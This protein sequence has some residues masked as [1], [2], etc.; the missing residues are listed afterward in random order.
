MSEEESSPEWLDMSEEE[1]SPEGLVMKESSP[2]GLIMDKEELTADGLLG[3][4]DG[5]PDD[6][7]EDPPRPPVHEMWFEHDTWEP[8]DAE[9]K[10][11]YGRFVAGMIERIEN[12]RCTWPEV[13]NL[14]HLITTEHNWDFMDVAMP[15]LPGFNAGQ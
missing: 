15:H 6:L 14:F 7:F 12:D 3:I 4:M 8:L 10:V 11:Q 2:E 5:V 9:G 1:S 13:M